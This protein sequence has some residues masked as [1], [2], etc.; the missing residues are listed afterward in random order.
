MMSQF[1]DFFVYLPTET[2]KNRSFGSKLCFI[3]TKV[4]RDERYFN[5]V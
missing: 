3:E 4:E 5:A 1:E 2:S